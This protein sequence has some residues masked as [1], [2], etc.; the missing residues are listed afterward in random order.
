MKSLWSR[1]PHYSPEI[2]VLLRSKAI[3]SLSFWIVW[4]IVTGGGSIHMLITIFKGVGDVAGTGLLLI[5]FIFSLLFAHGSLKSILIEEPNLMSYFSGRVPGSGLCSGVR[6]LLNSKEIDAY[7][8]ANHLKPLGSMISADDL[9]DRKE[10]SW[11]SPQEALH[12][13]DRL[14]SVREK[15][16]TDCR[17]DLESLKPRLEYAVAHNL[18]FCFL[19]RTTHFTNSMEWEKRKGFC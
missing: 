5:V 18:K 10:I 15:F 12:L 1:L 3:R 4:L 8:I 11:G 13:V 9:F 17:E 14:L 16:S 19:I 6:L 7:A 2:A